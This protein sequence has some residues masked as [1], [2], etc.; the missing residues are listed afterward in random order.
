MSDVRNQLQTL[1]GADIS[2]SQLSTVGGK[3]F[4]N[5]QDAQVDVHALTSWWRAIHVP[6]Y[7]QPIPGSAFAESVVGDV[8]VYAPGANESAQ[9]TALTITNN[10]GTTPASPNLLIGNQVVYQNPAIPPGEAVVVIGV[11][12]V[13]LSI[14]NGQTLSVQVGGVPPADVTT[15]ASGFL[16]VQ[17]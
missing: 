7:G 12:D 8:S 3:V 15:E 10:N 11:G 16:V 5:A 1:T 17:G 14:V 6:T 9:I 2:A 4:T 13:P